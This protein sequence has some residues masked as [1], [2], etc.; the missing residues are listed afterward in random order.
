MPRKLAGCGSLDQDKAMFE[1][2]IDHL[3]RNTG[4]LE[5]GPPSMNLATE[6]AS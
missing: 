3:P 1:L 4:G 5:V 2:L 6:P